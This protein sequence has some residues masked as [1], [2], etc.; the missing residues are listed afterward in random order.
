[1]R[2]PD[3]QQK[4]MFFYVSAEDRIPKN[5]PL[6]PVKVMVDAL[7]KTLDGQF[8][9]MYAATGRPSIAPE[10]LLRALLLQILYSIR[11]ERALMEHIDFNILFRW[12][13]GLH[14]DEPVWDHSSFS[15][16]RDRLIDSEIALSFLEAVLEKARAEGLL[17]NDHFSVDGTLLEAWASL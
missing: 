17:S 9:R 3:H 13:V 10:C 14:L 5:H 11:S 12:F 16:N 8:S 2:T 1:M 7:L 15:K 6:R 4:K